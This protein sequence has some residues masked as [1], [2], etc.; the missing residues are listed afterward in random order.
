MFGIGGLAIRI[1][2]QI[3][4]E[5]SLRTA[6]AQKVIAAHSVSHAER[7]VAVAV[8]II[9]HGGQDPILLTVHE[10]VLGAVGRRA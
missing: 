3:H 10:T 5:S 1:V 9:Q 4:A 8:V 6:G 2:E 7:G